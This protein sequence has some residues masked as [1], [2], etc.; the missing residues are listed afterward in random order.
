[1]GTIPFL[2]KVFFLNLNS[3]ANLLKWKKSSGGCQERRTN[4]F[5]NLKADD[6]DRGFWNYDYVMNL[7]KE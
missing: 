1:M 3:I 5:S 2:P 4:R 7:A 6:T